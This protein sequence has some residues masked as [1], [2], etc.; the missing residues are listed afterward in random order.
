MSSKIWWLASYPKSGNT[1]LRSFIATLLSGEPADINR[2]NFLGANSASR[3]AFDRVIG[4]EAADLSLKQ[5]LTLRPRAYQVWAADARRPL[6][7]KAHE[8][9]CLTPAG[10]PLFPTAATWGAIYV[11]RDPRSVAVSLAHHLA[12]SID[13][14]I[15]LMEDPEAAFSRSDRRLHQ[16]LHQRLT[17]WS[18]HVDSWRRA[19]FPVHLVR[20]EDMQAEPHAAFGAL[21]TVL[22]LPSDRDAIA[23]AVESTSFGRLQAQERAS[24]FAEKPYQMA[25]FF[26]E[27]R[28]EG[29][30]EAL[31]P[32][33]VARLTAVHGEVMRRLGYGAALAPALSGQEPLDRGAEAGA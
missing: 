29:W 6:Y 28:S 30:R 11:V 24:G 8:A 21:A 3:V 17:S 33:Q 23:A 31:T 27:G 22:G 15:A 20:Y 16:Q 13:R 18:E 4:I 7:C 12:V 26:R 25:T 1:W 9:Y 14:A 2:M 32:E 19:P 10:E 5:Q